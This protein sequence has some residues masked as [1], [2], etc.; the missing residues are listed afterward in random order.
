MP[1][2]RDIVGVARKLKDK[3][4]DCHFHQEFHEEC[5]S[6]LYYFPRVAEALLIAVEALKEISKTGQ[7]YS[8]QVLEVSVADEALSRIHSLPIE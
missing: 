5:G 1:P 8:G 6:R 7:D 2:K 3:N 4:C